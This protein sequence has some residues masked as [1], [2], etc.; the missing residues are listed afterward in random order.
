MDVQQ[1]F[2][3]SNADATIKSVHGNRRCRLN[4]FARNMAQPTHESFQPPFLVLSPLTQG[5]SPLKIYGAILRLKNLKMFPMNLDFLKKVG[6]PLRNQI[7]V[8]PIFQKDMIKRPGL[9]LHQNFRTVVLTN[10]MWDMILP[11]IVVL[12]T[13]VTPVIAMIF[14]LTTSKKLPASWWSLANAV[15]NWRGSGRHPSLPQLHLVK[16]QFC[17]M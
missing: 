7:T 12:V 8:V 13:P 16:H 11:C 5:K 10:V 1:E 9:G 4:D 6:G 14:P 17:A 15:D 3:L 2:T